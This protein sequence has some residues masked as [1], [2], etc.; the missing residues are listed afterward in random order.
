M[1][2]GRLRP[3]GDGSDGQA[4]L[5]VLGS[6]AKS[7]NSF[8]LQPAHHRVQTQPVFCFVF[9]SLSFFLKL[10]FSVFLSKSAKTGCDFL[11]PGT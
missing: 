8:P 7:D 9:P 4:L 3:K 2:M 11:W 5:Q 6:G 10:R 1:V